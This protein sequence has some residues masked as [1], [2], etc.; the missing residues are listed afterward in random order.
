[1]NMKFIFCQTFS[2]LGIAWRDILWFSTQHRTKFLNNTLHLQIQLQN[3]SS[4]ILII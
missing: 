4:V 1:M 2:L 3:S